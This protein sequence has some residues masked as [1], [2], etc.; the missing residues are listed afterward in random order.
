MRT[1]PGPREFR[2]LWSPLPPMSGII[3]DPAQVARPAPGE[4]EGRTD[5]GD[6]E[7]PP[8]GAGRK[9]FKREGKACS[10]TRESNDIWLGVGLWGQER[11][12]SG[13]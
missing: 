10:V 8:R 7:G 1:K 13:E 6:V 3:C 5:C 11:G 4:Q 9:A 12:S 2:A